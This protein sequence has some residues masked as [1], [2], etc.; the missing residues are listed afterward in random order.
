MRIFLSL[1]ILASLLFFPASSFAKTGW[2][3]VHKGELFSDHALVERTD[4]L[5]NGEIWLLETGIGCMMWMQ[6]DKWAL[7]DTGYG[8]FLDGLSDKLIIPDSYT[9]KECKIWDAFKVDD[10]E[11]ELYGYEKDEFLRAIASLGDLSSP[12]IRSSASTYS[13]PSYSSQSSAY[14]CPAHSSESIS[15]SSK[16]TCDTGYEINKS[17]TK[18]TKISA[19]KNDKLCQA[20][21]GKNSKWNKKYS[22]DGSP[23]CICKPKY[24][25]NEAQTKCIKP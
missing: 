7:F 18:C 25:W 9:N 1:T 23:E 5:Y 17:K 15:D 4:S 20:D 6:D 21:F 12:P 13:G 22:E 19:K 14:S 24:E 3:Y 8:T 11:Y 16:C 10:W 2:L